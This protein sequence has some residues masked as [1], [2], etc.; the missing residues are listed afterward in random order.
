MSKL[1]NL[2]GKKF[3]R[4]TVIQRYGK[5]KQ[6]NALWLCLCSCGIEKLI[7]SNQL[8]SGGTI[9]CGCFNKEKST[10]HGHYKDN[11]E[12]QTH[13]SWHH[14]IDRCKNT[15]HHAYNRY[16]GRGINICARWQNFENFLKDMGKPPTKNHS[17][18]RIDNNG[19]YCKF[20]CRWATKKEQAR[21]RSNNSLVLYKGKTQ[22]IAAWAEE[23]DIDYARLHQRI[24]RWHW[25]IHKALTTPVT[26]G[27]KRNGNNDNGKTNSR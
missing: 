17:I 5:D 27:R 19:N 16:G 8:I 2:T 18:D 25:S 4:L 14:M 11:Q 15:K 9:S 26:K 7:P 3:N 12:S 13:V 1:I 10:T 6:G 20:N 23:F 21:N 22:C 24:F